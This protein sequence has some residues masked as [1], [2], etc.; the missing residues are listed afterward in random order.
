MVRDFSSDWRPS[1]QLR[2]TSPAPTSMAA[3][4]AALPSSPL[5]TFSKVL[6]AAFLARAG[7]HSARVTK[8][9]AVA[10]GEVAAS[11]FSRAFPSQS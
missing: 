10:A 5:R 1:I 9:W 11:S 7:S 2:A 8:P 3:T 4:A 6:A